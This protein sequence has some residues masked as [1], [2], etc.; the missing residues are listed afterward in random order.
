MEQA[1]QNRM[2]SHA[3]GGNNRDCGVLCGERMTL[4]VVILRWALKEEQNP[5]RRGDRKGGEESGQQ[6][7]KEQ[8][9]QTASGVGKRGGE[10]TGGKERNWW[11]VDG[12]QCSSCMN[13]PVALSYWRISIRRSGKE[14]RTLPY[15]YTCLHSL[16]HFFFLSFF[17]SFSYRDNL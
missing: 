14:N 11:R 17:F 8:A 1:E 16:T 12:T 2:E 3:D 15:E 10:K 13:A 5:R 7:G 4:G 6:T 9:A